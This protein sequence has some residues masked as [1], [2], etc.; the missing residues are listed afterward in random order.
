V[1]SVIGQPAVSAASRQPLGNGAIG[2]FGGTFDPVHYGHLRAALEAREKLGVQ[3]LRLLPAGQPPHREAPSA[4]PRHR[5]AMLE[6]AVEGVPGFTVDDREVRRGGHSYMSDTLQEIRQEAGPVPLL[7]LIGQDAANGL[8]R[9]HEWRSLFDLAH[10]VVMR[11]PNAH[12]S[13]QGELKQEMA[14]RRVSRVEDILDAPAGRVLP[15]PVTQLEISATAIRAMIANGNSPGF[16]LPP[17]VVDYI[18]RHHLYL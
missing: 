11:R 10:L 14:R 5:L 1:Q 4:S 3:E 12:G 18:G 6:R 8:D 9:W 15:L 13:Y 7:L 16:L 2:I 17:T